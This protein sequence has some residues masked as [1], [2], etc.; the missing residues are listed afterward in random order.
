[1]RDIYTAWRIQ[2]LLYVFSLSLD[3]IEAR[4][5]QQ[6]Q[7]KPWAA[8]YMSIILLAKIVRSRFKEP[9]C[10]TLD[11]SPRF[12][13]REKDVDRFRSVLESDFWDASYDIPLK[14][15]MTVGVAALN[16]S[17]KQGLT[18]R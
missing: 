7:K 2:R 9:I 8:V 14:F 5:D 1:M 12:Q 17:S 18:L 13:N 16:A 11:L 4:V 10:A 3:S 6:N 15:D